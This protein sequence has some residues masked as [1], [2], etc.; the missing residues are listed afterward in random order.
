M[1]DGG[2]PYGIWKLHVEN[3][4]GETMGETL[5]EWSALVRRPQLGISLNPVNGLSNHQL[6][7][8]A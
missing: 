6:Q 1:C 2:N 8:Q 7:V 3:H 4:K 5:A